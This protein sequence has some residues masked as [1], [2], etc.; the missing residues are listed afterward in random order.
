MS[1]QYIASLTEPQAHEYLEGI[2]WPGGQVVCPK[3][4]V[5]GNARLM[6]GKS[7]PA[8]TWKCRDCL[9]KFTVRVGTIFEDSHIPLR[10]WLIAFSMMCASKKGVSALQL[11]RELEL[12]S[13]KSAWHMAHRIRYAMKEGP[14]RHLLD[15]RVEVDE[16]YIGGKEKNKHAVDRKHDGRGAVGKAPVV[17]LIAR[18][19]T[20]RAEVPESVGAKNLRAMLERNVAKTA[21]LYTDELPAYK[22]LTSVFR[23][24]HETVEHGTGE[25]VRGDVHINTLEGFFSLLKRGLHGAYHHVDRKH[26]QRYVDEFAFRYNH[27]VSGDGARMNVALSQTEGK[28]L[29]YRRPKSAA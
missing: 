4:G 21:T 25:Y 8:R 29:M 2:R 24:G 26:L 17:A 13:Y 9:K 23:G 7:T 11:Q 1:T 3:C 14:F 19:G 16:C 20:L 5:I 28:R 12:G 27:R 22:G 15:G 10:K 18:D 6:T